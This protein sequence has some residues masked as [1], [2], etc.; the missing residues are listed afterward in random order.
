MIVCGLDS[1]VARRWINGLVMSL[2]EYD[3]E[4]KV[5]SGSIPIIDGGTEGIK[6]HA[7]VIIPGSSA[8]IECTLDLYPP[9]VC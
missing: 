8:C 6:G 2:V 4:G 9:Q 3:D 7:R 5:V 1:I